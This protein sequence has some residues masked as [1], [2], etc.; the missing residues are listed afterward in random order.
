M[1]SGPVDASVDGHVGHITMNR[2]DKRNALTPEMVGL[3]RQ[4]QVAILGVGTVEKR[5]VHRPIDGAEA[6]QFMEKL[7][8]RIEE[9]EP[10]QL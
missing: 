1:G 4:P 5:P 3:M 10:N 6:N 7:K 2:P 9:F 8:R